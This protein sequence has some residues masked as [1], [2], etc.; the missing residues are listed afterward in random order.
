MQLIQEQFKM[1]ER[2]FTFREFLQKYFT[3]FKIDE[4]AKEVVRLLGLWAYRSEDFEKQKEPYFLDKGN[5]LLGN[6]GTGKTEIMIILQRYLSYLKS[7]YIFRRG[8][9][10]AF[11][12]NFKKESYDCFLPI[13]QG[14]WFFDELG[15]T[16]ERTGELIKESVNH[17]GNK[18][19]V[20]EE[21]ILKRYN[22]FKETGYQTSFTCNLSPKQIKDAYG[23]RSYSRLLEMCNFIN[24]YGNDRRIN[25][26]PTFRTN[27]NQYIPD[28]PQISKEEKEEEIIKWLNEIYLDFIKTGNEKIIYTGF[29]EM[30]KSRG[31]QIISDEDLRIIKCDVENEK[32]EKI[33]ANLIVSE[34]RQERKDLKQLLEQY[35]QKNINKNE[36][37]DNW[38]EAKKRALIIYFKKCANENK[39]EILKY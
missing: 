5:L 39:Q 2:A 26:R 24:Y 28:S 4:Q 11:A 10:W 16:D 17:Y 14:N 3:W 18:I 33:R 9:V 25:I 34:S 32:L 35:E 27:Q 38:A 15:L 36:D 20:G 8:I 1:E 6:V 23:E 13:L 37:N 21:L 19:L 12:D 22:I 7:P 30:Y 31:C 29:F